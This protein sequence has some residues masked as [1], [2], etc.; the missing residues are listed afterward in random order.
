MHG[1][2]QQSVT[3]ARG[4]AKVT[5][6]VTSTSNPTSTPPTKKMISKGTKVTKATVIPKEINQA[7]PTSTLQTKETSY[8]QQQLQKQ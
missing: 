3:M 5:E 1:Q 2:M 6:K 8:F 7:N 4:T